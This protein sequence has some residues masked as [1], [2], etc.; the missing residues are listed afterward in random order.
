MGK[1]IAESSNSENTVVPFSNADCSN[2]A[3]AQN[4]LDKKY[5]VNFVCTRQLSYIGVIL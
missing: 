2:T 4:G 5:I 1:Y 3:K